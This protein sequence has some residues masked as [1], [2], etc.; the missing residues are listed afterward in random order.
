MKHP[1][2]A[3]TNEDSTVMKP[4]KMLSQEGKLEIIRQEKDEGPSI[5]GLAYD[6]NESR[7]RSVMRNADEIERSV[8]QSSSLSALYQ[9]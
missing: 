5:F 2:S 6:I 7:I 9:E 8:N 1:T 3:F 4:Q